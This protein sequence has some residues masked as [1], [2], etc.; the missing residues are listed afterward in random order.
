M[1]VTAWADAAGCLP[2]HKP[3]NQL[4]SPTVYL[5][6]CIAAELRDVSG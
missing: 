5:L 4:R 6:N 3:G 2:E 1:I